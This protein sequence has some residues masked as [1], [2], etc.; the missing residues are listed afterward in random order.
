MARQDIKELRNLPLADLISAPLNAVITAQANAALS[1][2]N[3][4]ERIGFIS[5]S[6][7]SIFDNKEMIGD[8][9]DTH[10]VRMA[11]LKVK[12]KILVADGDTY[13]VEEIEEYV[14]IPFI[15]LFNIPAFE[16]GSL[17]WDFKVRLK[18]VQEFETNFSHSNTIATSNTTG[19]ELG[20]AAKILQVGVN[21]TMTVEASATT[22]FELRYKSNREQEYNL[23]INVKGNAAPFPKGIERL[24]DI[25]ERIATETEEANRFEAEK[26]AID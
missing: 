15:T 24:L 1:T 6:D 5:N 10:R 4:I 20:V 23:H 9:P 26:Q 17:D 3:F 7:K 19:V 8:N 22:D 2:A 25:A 16:I 13:K 14:A 12:K 21:T 11:E 18:S